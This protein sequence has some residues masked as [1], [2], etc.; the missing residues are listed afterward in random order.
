M[1]DHVFLDCHAAELDI[2][3]NDCRM[4]GVGPGDGR[5]LEIVGGLEPAFDAAGAAMIPAGARGL[6]H[7]RKRHGS[8]RHPDDADGTVAQLEIAR[9]AFEQVGADRKHLFA[10]PLT[11]MMDCRR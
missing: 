8:A 1:G 11:G 5:R 4:G 9:R 10:K 2:D 7:L 6:R 3:R